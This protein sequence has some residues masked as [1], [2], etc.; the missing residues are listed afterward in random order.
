MKQITNN[1]LRVREINFNIIR[2]CFIQKSTATKAEI[3]KITG[4]S[5]AT[6]GSV[7]NKMVEAGEIFEGELEASNGG[8][9]ARRYLYNSNFNLVA[10]LMVLVEGEK[11]SIKAIVANCFGEIVDDMEVSPE[12][13][14]AEVVLNTV[15]ALKEKHNTISVVGIGAPAIIRDQVILS[16]DEE[17]LENVNFR[18]LLEEQVGVDTVVVNDSQTKVWGYYK[19]DSRLRNKSVALLFIPKDHCTGVGIISGGRL[20]KGDNG[21]A[22]EV[23]FLPYYNDGSD[24]EDLAK[25]VSAIISTMVAVINPSVFVING[26]KMGTGEYSRDVL[27][28]INERCRLYIPEQFMPDVMFIPDMSEY[29]AKGL[30]TILTERLYDDIRLVNEHDFDR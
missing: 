3:A 12:A 23:Q 8:R 19:G 14:T 13:V 7:L 21:I 26:S 10:G 15:R 28:K 2:K 27:D 24:N 11:K 17:Q 30:I 9:P 1:N 22:G 25:E 18:E 20:I 16:C 29:Y 4:L 6:C 5:I